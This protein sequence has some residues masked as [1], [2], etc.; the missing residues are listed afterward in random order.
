MPRGNSTFFVLVLFSLC[1]SDLHHSHLEFSGC[2]VGFQDPSQ[3]ISSAGGCLARWRTMDDCQLSNNLDRNPCRCPLCWDGG[4][5]F[6]LM[7]MSYN[8]PQRWRRESKMSLEAQISVTHPHQEIGSHHP[9][10]Q[11]CEQPTSV[12]GQ[13]HQR[14]Q[15]HA[16]GS[17]IYRREAM[18]LPATP[19]IARFFVAQIHTRRTY[20]RGKF[21]FD[22]RLRGGYS[23]MQNIE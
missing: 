18:N 23:V 9:S 16:V 2:L 6:P 14:Y 21:L 3:F 8:H 15:T 20:P 17:C 1:R 11:G 12:Y 5:I 10:V 13:Q 4:E 22:R 19:S 7:C